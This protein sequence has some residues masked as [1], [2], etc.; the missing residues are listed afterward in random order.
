MTV[1]IIVILT[2]IRNKK[3]TCT[4]I[5]SQFNVE[6][7]PVMCQWSSPAKGIFKQ[8]I[9]HLKISDHRNFKYNMT[10]SDSMAAPSWF[11]Y[12]GL[13]G[14]YQ[15]QCNGESSSPLLLILNLLKCNLK[16]LIRAKTLMQ[17][18]NNGSI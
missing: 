13:E 11:Y 18:L 5:M 1:L 3:N 12:D 10:L 17:K 14:T 9:A 7:L 4:S 8:A 16:V 2:C 6:Y 15:S